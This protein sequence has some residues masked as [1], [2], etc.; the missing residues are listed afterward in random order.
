MTNFADSKLNSRLR[1]FESSVTPHAEAFGL[2]SG[3][4]GAF[5]DRPSEGLAGACG[6]L[7]RLR[8]A[9]CAQQDGK[10]APTASPGNVGFKHQ[11]QPY[12]HPWKQDEREQVRSVAE[13]RE[14]D[15][16]RGSGRQQVDR[17]SAPAP[18]SFVE[19]SHRGQLPRDRS[20]QGKA[21]SFA[22][23]IG[24]SLIFL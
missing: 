1:A 12:Q 11:A 14:H 9:W 13:G 5:R 15:R 23:T 17:E 16:K 20:L 4:E 8:S 7:D 22:R 2:R 10:G 18:K 19:C 3:F 24:L 21:L 6:S